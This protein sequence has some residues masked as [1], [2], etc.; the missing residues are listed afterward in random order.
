MTEDEKTHS[1][2]QDLHILVCVVVRTPM[3]GRHLEKSGGGR[4]GDKTVE[5]REE[6]IS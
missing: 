6:N 4:E 5:K 3:Q 2:Q 1:L